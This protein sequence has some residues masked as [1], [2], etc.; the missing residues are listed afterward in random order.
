ME[1]FNYLYKYECS[2]TIARFSIQGINS[3]SAGSKPVEVEIVYTEAKKNLKRIQKMIASY[4]FKDN[5]DYF[6]FFYTCCVL[7]FTF[8]AVSFKK[9]VDEET[10][11]LKELIQKAIQDCKKIKKFDSRISFTEDDFDLL[12]DS[13]PQVKCFWNWTPYIEDYDTIFHINLHSNFQQKCRKEYV[14]LYKTGTCNNKNYDFN[15]F[16]IMYFADFWP[17]SKE[18]YTTWNKNF[19]HWCACSANKK[20]YAENLNNFIINYFHAYCTDETNTKGNLYNFY[21]R[22]EYYN[23]HGNRFGFFPGLNP[24]KTKT[25][26]ERLND[27][28]ECSKIKNYKDAFEYYYPRL[29][30]LFTTIESYKDLCKW[31]IYDSL[32]KDKTHGLENL[33]NTVFGELFGGEKK[34][35]NS[36]ILNDIRK[37]YHNRYKNNPGIVICLYYL[38]RTMELS[39]IE[40]TLIH[41]NKTEL[42]EKSEAQNLENHNELTKID[43]ATL[44]LFKC[45]YHKIPHEELI[46]Q[47]ETKNSKINE[48]DSELIEMMLYFAFWE[49]IG[50][51]NCHEHYYIDNSTGDLTY[52]SERK[53]A[54]HEFYQNF[55]N[56]DF[57]YEAQLKQ[58]LNKLTKFLHFNKENCFDSINFSDQCSS[59]RVIYALST[60][61]SNPK[62]SIINLMNY[63]HELQMK[64]YSLHIDTKICFEDEDKAETVK[65]D[66]DNK[67]AKVKE[68]DFGFEIPNL[69]Q[70]FYPFNK[71]S[72]KETYKDKRDVPGVYGESVEETIEKYKP[73]P[74]VLERKITC[75]L[76][77]ETDKKL[78]ISITQIKSDKNDLN[79][80]NGLFK[81][82]RDEDFSITYSNNIRNHYMYDDRSMSVHE[83]VLK[84]I[85]RFIEDNKIIDLIKFNYETKKY[86][87][88]ENN[89]IKGYY[90]I[91]NLS[92]KLDYFTSEIIKAIRPEKQFDDVW[93]E[94]IGNS[95]K[96]N[97]KSSELRNFSLQEKLGTEFINNLQD[98]LGII[99]TTQG[100]ADSDGNEGDFLSLYSTQIL[101]YLSCLAFE[102]L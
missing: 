26:E 96:P 22:Y 68:S 17:K 56:G 32:F 81:L 62:D 49:N 65:K 10:A 43:L 38:L 44:L 88:S 6:D 53:Q 77:S 74:P 47:D 37:D 101:I 20:D 5:Q 16:V 3:E 52:I 54:L 46:F 87:E 23:N 91:K 42:S 59:I 73:L 12:P 28:T 83:R 48:K 30:Y 98:F 79:Y 13:Y 58:I 89:D 35:W 27:I 1:N 4:S 80:N 69:M 18:N 19:C 51:W 21:G 85:Q 93:T 97:I 11:V 64:N 41:T 92:L 63:V 9:N 39:Y 50:Y 45:T 66:L 2:E 82:S 33:I 84:C 60:M 14:K 25:P 102:F 29:H 70:T 55:V 72:I 40:K 78:T 34:Q 24:E 57:S 75:K 15:L 67:F 7:Y 90:G 100:L 31:A 86:L 95:G 61:Y 36:Q 71:I 8:K 76:M 94:C 99:C